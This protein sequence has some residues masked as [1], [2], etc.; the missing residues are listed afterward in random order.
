MCRRAACAQKERLCRHTRNARDAR[1]ETRESSPNSF[2]LS[3][4]LHCFFVF[5]EKRPCCVS[6]FLAGQVRAQS[7]PRASALAD[8]LPHHVHSPPPALTSRL[9]HASSQHTAGERLHSS[10]SAHKIRFLHSFPQLQLATRTRP[11]HT[12]HPRL[13]TYPLN[14]RARGRP[15]RVSAMKR[16]RLQN[17]KALDTYV[18]AGGSKHFRV[19][20]L[21][22]I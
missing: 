19:S 7:R 11:S 6:F 16:G 1:R 12:S 13:L 17:W 10:R 9:A 5:F 4:A 3:L 8:A 18:W 20:F 2:S 22:T 21:K 14:P 15:R